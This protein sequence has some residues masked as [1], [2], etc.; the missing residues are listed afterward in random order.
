ME[1]I[2]NLDRVILEHNIY[3]KMKTVQNS[4]KNTKNVR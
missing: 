4:I 3:Y 2:K 1:Q